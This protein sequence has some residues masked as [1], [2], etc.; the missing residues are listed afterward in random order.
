[1]C[2]TLNKSESHVD[3]L[4]YSSQEVNKAAEQLSR[5]SVLLLIS[6]QVMI[7]GS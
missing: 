1:M 5:L 7:S 4:M 2:Q 6:P 3:Y